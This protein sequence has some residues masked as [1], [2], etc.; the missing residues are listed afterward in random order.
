MSHKIDV[1]IV[2]AG[3]VG[4]TVAIELARRNINVRIVEQR[5]KPSTR[6]K[7]LVVHARTLEFFDILGIAEELIQRGYMHKTRFEGICTSLILA[8][9]DTY[10]AFDMDTLDANIFE[11][12]LQGWKI[13]SSLYQ[14]PIAV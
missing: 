2:G 4:L 9:L 14:I 11:K 13:P 7:A 1:L 6:S 3:L 8:F 5:D 10:V 12:Q